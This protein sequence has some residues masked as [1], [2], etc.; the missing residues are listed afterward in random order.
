MG[1]RT[2]SAL[3]VLAALGTYAQ[4]QVHSLVPGPSVGQVLS[5]DLFFDAA[6]RDHW[7]ATEI[8][9]AIAQSGALFVSP[10]DNELDGAPIP[11][12]PPVFPITPANPI[13]DTFLLAPSSATGSPGVAE[14]VF[15]P[16]EF[17]VVWFDTPGAQGPDPAWIARIAFTVPDSLLNHKKFF[18]NTIGIGRPLI[19]LTGGT[20]TKLG[21]SNVT[22]FHNRPGSGTIIIYDGVFDD[23][24]GNNIPDEDDIAS[25]FSQDCQD[26]AIPDECQLGGSVPAFEVAT[27]VC[28]DAPLACPGIVYTGS[29]LGAGIEGGPGCGSD[30]SPD[31]WYRYVPATNGTL[32]V[33]LCGSSYDTA[34]SLHTDCPSRGGG[35]QLACNDDYCEELKSQLTRSVL[36]GETYYIRISGYDGAAGDYRMILVGPPCPLENVNCDLDLIPDACEIEADASNDC[37]SNG[38]LDTCEP[39]LGPNREVVLTLDVS[40]SIDQAELALEIE[41]LLECLHDPSLFPTNESVAVGVVVYGV[42]A[43]VA[44]PLTPLSPQ[45][46][47]NQVEPA[48]LGLLQN[49]LVSPGQT[50]LGEGVL[51][52]RNLLLAS[53]FSVNHQQIL[54]VGDGAATGG[55]SI[56]NECAVAAQAGIVIAAIAVGATP[57][58]QAELE[59]CALTTGGPFI[60]AESFADFGAV[61]A[62]LLPQLFGARLEMHAAEACYL[63]GQMLIVDLSMRD[64]PTPVVG[65]QFFLQYATAQLDLI[66]ISPAL[67]SPFSQE[68]GQ[69]VNEAAGTVDYAIGLPVGGAPT[70]D[71]GPLARLTF[72][73]TSSGQFCDISGLVRFRPHSPPTRLSDASGCAVY[74]ALFDLPPTHIDGVGPVF[75]FVQGPIQVQGNPVDCSAEVVLQPAQAHDACG[76]VEVTGVR[77]DGLPLT[78]PYPVGLT[79]ITWT[80]VDE[81]GNP[82]VAITPVTVLGIKDMLLTVQLQGVT[83]PLLTRCLTVELRA[84]NQAPVTIERLVQFVN[85]YAAG[86]PITI[87]CGVY[88]CLM[89]RD[90]LHTTRRT[91]SPIPTAGTFYAGNF[92]GSKQLLGGN[93]NGDAFIDVLD[94][95]IFLGSFG[96]ALPSGSTTC[97]TLGPHADLSGDGLVFV[98]DFTFFQVNF[99]AADEPGCCPLPTAP[100]A[101]GPLERVSVAD[102]ES[103]G[104]PGLMAGDVNRDGWVDFRDVQEFLNSGSH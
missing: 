42:G 100:P 21:A 58:G 5:F 41:G 48:L 62:A 95:A 20:V 79:E 26:D 53:E 29:T 89:V 16:E 76:V 99:P 3:A 9:L 10:L 90:K 63:P 37:N 45:S 2:F 54:L 91:I 51:T 4:A 13:R 28:D 12:A 27:D 55:P 75:D 102:L 8:T 94:F 17:S 80:A 66:D 19:E 65:G 64:V 59:D 30:N 77:S 78:A 92:T 38:L 71:D 73:V 49:R 103:S 93:L 60:N 85:G 18:P 82:S 24:N 43:A 83:Q 101:S 7:N 61:C 56:T 84:C 34:V 74:P 23:C 32:T 50:F 68:V 6:N 97:T 87:P 98:E 14:F 39:G 40:T 88:D 31:V 33:S 46:L 44:L 35:V 25:G 86:V 96:Q 11:W 70:A 22:G 72:V 69:V 104:L 1:M 67:G 57:A 81:C 47:V 36:A 15:T 52:A